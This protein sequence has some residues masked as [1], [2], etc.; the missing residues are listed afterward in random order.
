MVEFSR[1]M[2]TQIEPL[3]R[4]QSIQVESSAAIV[5]CGRAKQNRVGP[6]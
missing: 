6:W 2:E 4:M 3:Y 5:D 1:A